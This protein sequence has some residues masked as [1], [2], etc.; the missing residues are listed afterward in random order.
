MLGGGGILGVPTIIDTDLGTTDYDDVFDVTTAL[1]YMKA[2]TTGLGV[3]G[4]G[5]DLSLT[6]APGAVDVIAHHFGLNPP[7]QI[8]TWKG[9]AYNG[10]GDAIASFLYDG[11]PHPETGLAATVQDAVTMYRTLLAAR[12]SRDMWIAAIGPLHQINALLTSAADGISPLTGVQLVAAKCAGLLMVAGCPF[13][14]VLATGDGVATFLGNWQDF[15]LAGTFTD[16]PTGEYN[17]TQ[18]PA[19]ANAVLANWPAA[20][21]LIQVPIHIGYQIYVGGTIDANLNAGCP[22]RDGYHFW[23]TGHPWVVTDGRQAWSQP[24][25]DFLLRPS[26]YGTIKGTLSATVGNGYC[27]FQAGAAGPHEILYRKGTVTALTAYWNSQ[28]YAHG[29]N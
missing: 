3:F 16:S 24:A 20:S 13:Y 11:Y 19:A 7:T 29:P 15:S 6:K 9:G 23:A 14:R 2:G 28:I 18:Q 12:G 5:A 25:F 21:R 17:M 8:G 10:Q 27:T 26:L 1:Q 4:L 22:V